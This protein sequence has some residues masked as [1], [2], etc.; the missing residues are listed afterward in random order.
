MTDRSSTDWLAGLGAKLSASANTPDDRDCLEVFAAL[1]DLE[2]DGG[3]PHLLT[4]LLEPAG[5]VQILT[6]GHASPGLTV[7]VDQEL[8]L[9]LIQLWFGENE[10]RGLGPRLKQSESA[11]ASVAGSLLDRESDR[12]TCIEQYPQSQINSTHDIDSD[13]G[14]EHD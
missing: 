4:V 9:D 5:G 12:R 14:N 3:R 7:Q 13:E 2:R 8:Q 10:L 6:I 11:Q 1:L